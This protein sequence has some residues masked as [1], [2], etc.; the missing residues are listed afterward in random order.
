MGFKPPSGTTYDQR[1]FPESGEGRFLFEHGSRAPFTHA[2]T[3]SSR[4]ASQTTSGRSIA[5]SD[6]FDSGGQRQK[7]DHRSVTDGH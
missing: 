3:K 2:R 4:C 1:S 5:H 6:R 7:A